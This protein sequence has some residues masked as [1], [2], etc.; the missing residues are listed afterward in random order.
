MFVRCN[1]VLKS[2]PKKPPQNIRRI[3]NFSKGLNESR[4]K[5]W[6][7]PCANCMMKNFQERT[8]CNA[9][10]AVKPRDRYLQMLILNV[11]PGIFEWNLRPSL[12]LIYVWM[13]TKT[14]SY[15]SCPVLFSE[16]IIT[17]RFKTSGRRRAASFRIPIERSS[18]KSVILHWR[19][20]PFA[21]QPLILFRKW[22]KSYSSKE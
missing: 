19:M 11:L 21:L 9:R 1:Q 20:S 3:R 12:M 4:Q 14:T 10:T 5:I 18:I 7:I 15:N 16:R 13:K 22:R 8:V 17:V 2:F 6:I